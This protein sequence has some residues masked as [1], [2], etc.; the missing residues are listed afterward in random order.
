MR[1]KWFCIVILAIFAVGFIACG[2]SDD[3]V[4]TSPTKTTPTST[5]ET[6]EP[7]VEEPVEELPD[8]NFGAE[9]AAITAFLVSYDAAVNAGKRTT[10]PDELMAHWVDRPGVFFAHSLFGAAI[11]SKSYKK[12]WTTWAGLFKRQLHR[13]HQITAEDIGID[14]R[15]EKATITGRLQLLNQPIPIALGLEKDAEGMWKIWAADYGD[16]GLIKKIKTLQ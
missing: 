16:Q 13:A 12:I 2:G 7:V 6:T 11:N 14:A 8:V 4:E 10:K 15:G 9:R 1:C 3:E 5:T